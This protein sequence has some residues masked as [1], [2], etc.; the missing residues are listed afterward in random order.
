MDPEIMG[1]TTNAQPTKFRFSNASIAKIQINNTRLK[2]WDTGTK[3]L[4]LRVGKKKMFY[5][6]KR[7][8]GKDLYVK[9]GEFPYTTVEEARTEALKILT[10][11]SKGSYKKKGSVSSES[12]LKWLLEKY[13]EDRKTSNPPIK[14]STAKSMIYNIEH[15]LP[16]FLELPIEDITPDLVDK[17]YRKIAQTAPTTGHMVFR[18]LR[19]IMN[20]ANALAPEDAPVFL[21]NPVSVLSRR[22]VWAVPP[23]KTRVLSGTEIGR[24]I[25]AMEDKRLKNIHLKTFDSVITPSFLLFLLLTGARK[26]E[27]TGLLWE[28][29]SF[30]DMKVTFRDTKTAAERTIPIHKKLVSILEDLRLINATGKFVFPGSGKT[31]HLVVHKRALNVFFKANPDIPSFS[32]HDLRRTFITIGKQVT[33]GDFVEVIVGHSIQTVTGR[34][35]FHPSVEDLRGPMNLVAEKILSFVVKDP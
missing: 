2:L 33:P 22:R 15:Y 9:L 6:A 4:C 7:K 19:A 16:D 24:F 29:V 30:K 31:G 28:D 1:E 32:A 26:S 18:Y 14:E 35:Y 21:R 34:H 3:G 10:E 5:V 27:G 11:I 20:Y 13:V 25:L 12:T 8:D 17:A 23:P